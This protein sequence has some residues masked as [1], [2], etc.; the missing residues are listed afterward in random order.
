MISTGS[1]VFAVNSDLLKYWNCQIYW[2]RR[3]VTRRRFKRFERFESLRGCGLKD[4]PG[5]KSVNGV[6]NLK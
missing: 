6:Y 3:S 1:P 5:G 4:I 2:R